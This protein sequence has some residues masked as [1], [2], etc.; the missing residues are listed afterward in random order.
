MASRKSEAP[1][2]GSGES[3]E[4]EALNKKALDIVQRVRDKLTGKDFSKEVSKAT[5]MATMSLTY[6]DDLAPD[7][8]VTGESEDEGAGGPADPAGHQPREPVPVL[9][10]MVPLLVSHHHTGG[11]Q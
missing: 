6:V 1:L 9:H 7:P 3:V 2:G 5:I 4:P 8:D 10:R 11:R